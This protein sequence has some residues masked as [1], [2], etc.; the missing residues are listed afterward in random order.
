MIP[1]SGSIIAPSSGDTLNAKDPPGTPN[2]LAIPPSHV[3]AISNKELSGF[4]KFIITSSETWHSSSTTT[5]RYSPLV[6]DVIVN[7]E[8]WLSIWLL[9][10]NHW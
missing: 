4:P 1:K 10:K 2:I 8:F 7:W 3:A 5:T 6:E 9:F